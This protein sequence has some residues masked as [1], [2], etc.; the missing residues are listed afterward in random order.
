MKEQYNI[1]EVFKSQLEDYEMEV[2]QQAWANISKQIQ[3]PSP[4]STLLKTI[5]ANKVASIIAVVG[6]LALTG[7]LLNTNQDKKEVAKPEKK[8][9]KHSKNKEVQNAPVRTGIT[10]N[11][12]TENPDEVSTVIERKNQ[13]KTEKSD[14]VLIKEEIKPKEDVVYMLSETPQQTDET[15]Q[16]EITENPFKTLNKQRTKTIP[17]SI[18][19]VQMVEVPKEKLIATISASPV[20][21]YA[22]LNISFSHPYPNAK[23]IW[24]FD[25]GTLS[26]EPETQHT[27]E[28]PGEYNVQLIILSQNGDSSI[29]S[30]KFEVLSTSKIENI[31]N[32]FTPNNDGINDQFVFN[33][34]NIQSIELVIFDKT[35]NQIFT[36]TNI[37]EGWD[38][39]N[40]FGEPAKED[41]YI[42]IINARGKDGKTFEEKGVLKLAR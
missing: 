34:E 30:K 7:V 9:T 22:P 16:N 13:K 28:H 20:G 35:G 37:E 39:N 21:G 31:P 19:T 36:T 1:E 40:Q 38:G 29:A 8:A 14:P 17:Q 3:S 33:Y 32:I 25:D 41:N 24:N 4:A 42:Y 23:T 26:R 18:S 27:F 15:H 10:E 11:K 2:P 12:K 6:I 5:V